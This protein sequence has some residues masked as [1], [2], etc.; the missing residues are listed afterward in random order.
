MLLVQT[1]VWLLLGDL[2]SLLVL[3]LHVTNV[4]L[5]NLVIAIVIAQIVLVRLLASFDLRQSNHFVA[6]HKPSC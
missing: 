3:L 5:G 1:I 6:L 4:D 2:S